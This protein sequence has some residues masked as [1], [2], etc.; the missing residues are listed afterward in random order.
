MIK[1]GTQILLPG[2]KVQKG[3]HSAYVQPDQ[4]MFGPGFLTNLI[5]LFFTIVTFWI[6]GYLWLL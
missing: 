5:V 4:K 6:V 1:A 2:E 3:K